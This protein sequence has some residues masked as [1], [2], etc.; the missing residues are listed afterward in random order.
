[1]LFLAA[2]GFTTAAFADPK[3]PLAYPV[4]PRKRQEKKNPPQQS[5]LL[6]KI[7]SDD[8]EDWARTPN[9]LK[10]L[11]EWV[12][13]EMNVHFTSNIKIGRAHV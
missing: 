13:G 4:V 6:T 5:P 8:A 7:K 11:L 12:S 1:M 9:D 3:P 10:G 2:A